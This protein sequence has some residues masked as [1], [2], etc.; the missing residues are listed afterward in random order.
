MYLHGNWRC[1]GG[2]PGDVSHDFSIDARVPGCLHA[3]LARAGIIGDMF[4][5][6]SADKVQWIENCDVIY[7]TSFTLD[8]V[9]PDMRLTFEGL[10]VYAEIT[11]N[12][13]KLG[14][15]D[16]MFVPWSYD[17][18]HC[19]RTGENSL[20]VRFDSPIRRVKGLPRRGGAFTTERLY[21]RRIQCTYGWDWVARFVTMGIWRPVRLE[22]ILPDI[23]PHAGEGIH[24]RTLNINPYSAQVGIKLNFENITGDG[25]ADLRIES[26]EGVTVWSKRR[27]I[28]QN[29][30]DEIADI[31]SPSLWYPAGYGEQPLYTLI[32]T[33]AG[34]ERRV[35]FGIRELIILECEDARGTPE[36]ALAAK[37]KQYPHLVEWDKNEGSSC[38]IL[39]CNGVRIFCQGAN[40]VPSEPLPSEETPEK[41][42]RLVKTARFAGANML[43]VWGGGIFGSDAFYYACDREGILVTQDFLMACG[44]YPE[45]D[46]A[47]IAHLRREARAGALRLRNH[48]SLAWWSGD[49]ENAV[50]G[51]EN[52]PSYTGRRSALE[53]IAPVLSELDPG[54]RF[55]PSSPY[56][57]VPYASAVRGTTHNTQ[58]LG[59]FFGFVREDD[60]TDYRRYFDRYLSR[61][62]AEQPAIGM[63]FLS[64]LR[65]FMTDEDIFGEDTYISEYHTKNNPG[66]GDITLYGYVDRMA[67][68]IFGEYKDGAD[69]LRKMQM[70]QCEWIRLSMELFRRNAWFSSGIIY[71]MFNDCWPAAN[72]WSLV[73]YYCDPKP[74]MYMFRRCASPILASVTDS[75]GI[76]VHLSYNGHCGCNSYYEHNHCACGCGE[77][78]E[79]LRIASGTGRLYRYNIR[80]GAEDYVFPFVVE[81]EQGSAEVVFACDKIP[82]DSE[83]LLI[84][85]IE[86][87]TG[88]DRAYLLPLRYAD[89]MWEEGEPVIVSDTDEGITLEAPVTLPMAFV[90]PEGRLLEENGRFLKKGERV[91]Y[92]Y[93][94]L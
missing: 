17:V 61:F 20:T 36:A 44:N 37:I 30:I 13:V 80:T 48:P 94:R 90:D 34:G 45:E 35:T 71:W 85:D 54:R 23:L 93:S 58:F 78:H 8:R 1:S 84:A 63:P 87:N 38:F 92:R 43:R 28:L 59:N 40:W 33:D 11:L 72:G 76:E 6:D 2:I 66:L 52:N 19:L 82:L 60:F 27:R 15:T 56:G 67:R 24:V 86:T 83:T 74:S 55:L 65:K 68:G 51:D 12:G 39:L 21:T 91:I 81:L 79:S 10:D 22:R 57:G 69:R 46:D 18:S 47:F 7:S 3:D 14:E 88:S 75:D 73:D 53:G 50:R 89:M 26:P 41:V 62:N 29:E 42:D 32:V 31:V 49:N 25:W 5:R 64:S 70:L 9:E 16:N 4:R 77:D